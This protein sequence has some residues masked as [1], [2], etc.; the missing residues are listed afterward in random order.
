MELK[1]KKE[2][3]DKK[4][5][6]QGI[7]ELIL[8]E[9]TE[10]QRKSKIYIFCLEEQ[11]GIMLYGYPIDENDTELFGVPKQWTFMS[12]SEVDVE[13]DESINGQIDYFLPVSDN[14]SFATNDNTLIVSKNNFRSIISQ[15]SYKNLVLEEQYKI[16]SL[17]SRVYHLDPRYKIGTKRFEDSFI[18]KKQNDELNYFKTNKNYNNTD[19]NKK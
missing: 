1:N 14:V 15:V 16:I 4:K 7:L 12:L 5:I 8:R 17:S 2:K 10:N 3:A 6:Y 11:R 13:W 18:Q 19:K 9:K